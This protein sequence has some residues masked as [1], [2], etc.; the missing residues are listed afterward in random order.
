MN[1]SQLTIVRVIARLTLLIS[2]SIHAAEPLNLRHV[3]ITDLQNK[4]SLK[5]SQYS[6][7]LSLSKDFSYLERHYD[8]QQTEHVRMQQRYMGLP[9]FGGYAVLH[10]KHLSGLVSSVHMNGNIYRKLREDL[11]GC[12][13]KFVAN[14]SQ[15][16]Q[17]FSHSF[18]QDLIMAQSIQPIVY[19]DEQ[20]KAHWAYQIQLYLQSDDKLPTQPIVIIEENT[21]KILLQWDALTTWHKAVYGA[22]FGGNR[23]TVKY[24]YGKEKPY[25]DLIR[26]EKSGLCFLENGLLKVVDMHHRTQQP[27]HPMSFQCQDDSPEHTYWTG[28]AGDGYDQVNGSYSVSNDA[29][30]FGYLI[31]KM[32]REQ[33]GEEVLQKDRQ[34]VQLI[35]RIHFSNYFANAF[36]D[37]QQMTFGDGDSEF[38]SPVTIGIIAHELSHGFTQQHSGL[39]YFGQAGGINESFSDM[40]SQAAEYYA[41]GTATWTVGADVSKRDSA[42]RWFQHPSLD[43]VSIERA[44]D[45][46]NG[47]DVHYSSGV[48]NRLFYLLATHLDWDPQ[49][50]FHVMLKA[51]RDYWT[52]TTSFAEGACGILAASRDL[53]FSA[54]D[55][56]DVL[57][58]VMIDY[59]DC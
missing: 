9:V 5:L 52:P 43:G 13:P 6:A 11:G 31:K 55:V 18:P 47:M 21:G 4:I 54:G 41:H 30:Y 45:D 8:A 3:S 40:A 46:Q 10:R 44:T 25:L 16:L 28:Y 35:F 37:G 42:L 59:D 48:Y 33:Y 56:K 57:D 27:N 17:V 15:K 51:N 26:D 7:H 23:H 49:K 34:P 53:G 2:F 36:W 38:Y 1:Y 24:Q 20:N 58:K 29:M 39:F 12:P 22:G 32:Y 14:A 19:V 50:A